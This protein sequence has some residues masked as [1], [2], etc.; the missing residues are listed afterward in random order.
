MGINHS[1][2]TK[3]DSWLVEESPVRGIDMRSPESEGSLIN[4]QSSPLSTKPD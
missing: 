3:V 1:E 4:T 2:K